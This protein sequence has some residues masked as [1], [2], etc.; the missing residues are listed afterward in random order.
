MEAG[1]RGRVDVWRLHEDEAERAL[2]R[3]GEYL[4]AL[5]RTSGRSSFDRF[6]AELIYTE[7]IGN[8]MRH[9]SGPVDVHV[10]CDN[11]VALIRVCDR[12][13]GFVLNA[14]LPQE[15]L[16]DSG[17]GLYL[18]SQFAQRLNVESLPSR[19]TCVSVAFML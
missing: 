9:A 4:A 10:S 18:V 7:L 6:V 15:P 2:S 14:K 17:R 13:A 19:G 8:V 16:Q 11:D 12:G 3:R 1:T 5:E